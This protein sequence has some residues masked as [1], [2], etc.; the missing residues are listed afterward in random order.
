VTNATELVEHLHQGL[1]DAYGE[2]QFN[3]QAN[4][5]LGMN[6]H[7]S[8]DGRTIQVDHA[9]SI[10]KLVE[11]VLSDEHKACR[12]P[13]AEDMFDNDN[14]EENN[15]RLVEPQLKKFLSIVMSL[16]Y[17]AR[18]T[19][20]D[21]L[22]PVTYLA[23]RTHFATH[24][25]WN[26]LIRVLR[27]MKGTQNLGVRVKCTDLDLHCHCDASYGVHQEGRSHTG[28]VIY[29]GKTLSYLH[30]KSSKQKTGSTSSTDAE[31]IALIDSMKVLVWL[32]DV[33]TELDCSASRPAT[34]YQDNKS[35]ILMVTDVSK[36][37]RS[38]HILTKINYAKDLVTSGTIKIEYLNTHE[39]SADLLTKPLGGSVFLKHRDMIM[40]TKHVV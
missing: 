19:R 11:D 12:T 18:L 37:S 29:L 28:F 32:K 34:V 15:P 7:R 23:T 26:K 2:V 27:Y 22:L 5:Y 14:D 13:H 8:L 24:L 20:P 21:I 25:D 6:I 10:N 9:G 35:G 39:M 38:R 17:I 4:A 1:N 31:I 16:M 40:G 3:Q 33:L 30:A 36:Y